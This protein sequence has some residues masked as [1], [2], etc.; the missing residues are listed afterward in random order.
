MLKV[1]YVAS[2]AVTR[3]PTVDSMG[4]ILYSSEV[5]RI[6]PRR[7]VCIDSGIGLEIPDD[8]YGRLTGVRG[9]CCL[10]VIGG[11]IDADYRGPVKVPVYNFGPDAADINIGDPIA[12]LTINRIE[13]PL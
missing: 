6:E 3:F 12:R 11:V 13:R 9:D 1:P 5:R 2:A 8:Y 7:V 10:R 4:Y